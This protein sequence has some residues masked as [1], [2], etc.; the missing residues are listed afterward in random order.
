VPRLALPFA[1]PVPVG[2]PIEDQGF[3][4]VPATGPYVISSAGKEGVVLERNEEFR[5]RSAAAQPDGF[6]DRIEW[7][8]G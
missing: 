3:D 2:T 7:T 4:P 6:V 1:F 8:F 5:Q